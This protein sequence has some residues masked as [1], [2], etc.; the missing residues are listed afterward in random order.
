MPVPIEID[1]WQG[2]IAELEVDAIIVPANES[3]FMTNPAA[4]SVRRLAGE[5]VERDAVQ[6]GPIHPGT[7]VVT[8]GGN[9]AAAYLIHAVAVGHELHRNP[10]DLT[11]ALNAAFEIAARLALFRVAMAPI[12]AER[13]VFTAEEAAAALVEVLQT[14]S[15]AG[16]AVPASM[17]IAVA[18]PTEAAAFRSATEALRAAFR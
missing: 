17:V 15:R 7:A 2:E 14:R 6:Q 18:N 8:G 3:L 13:G 4:R 5:A 9:L 10:D 12:G 16:E 1:V 11:S